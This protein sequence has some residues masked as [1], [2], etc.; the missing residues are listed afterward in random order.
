MFTCN[1]HAL[2]HHILSRLFRN[3]AS[4]FN[5]ISK[6]VPSSTVTKNTLTIHMRKMSISASSI[7]ANL[8]QN[9]TSFLIKDLFQN[10]FHGLPHLGSSPLRAYKI[11]EF[12]LE[13]SF[14]S[15]KFFLH[16]STNYLLLR[17]MSFSKQQQQKYSKFSRPDFLL[18]C[19]KT[20]YTI[21]LCVSCRRNF[22][23]MT[24]KVIINKYLPSFFFY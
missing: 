5:L 8:F 1:K 2:L 3:I 19:P 14:L 10:M 15:Q 17:K 24:K 23:E 13:F 6:P 11:E 18:L 7:R 22:F 12:L 16:P 21:Y 4:F 20:S 9:V